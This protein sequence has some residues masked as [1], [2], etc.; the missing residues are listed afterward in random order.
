[1]T[2]LLKEPLVN[3]SEKDGRINAEEFLKTFSF[4]IP[5]SGFETKIL[6]FFIKFFFI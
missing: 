4:S 1:M 5:N 6:C 2:L 3:P